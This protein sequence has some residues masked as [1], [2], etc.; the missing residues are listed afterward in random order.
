MHVY[1]SLL[2]G[3]IMTKHIDRLKAIKLREKGMSYGQI[4]TKLGI[5]KGT[6][7]VWLRDMPLSESRISELR[8]FNPMR[9]E[10]YRNTMRKKRETRWGFVYDQVAKD[11]G[12][13][14]KRDVFIAGLF[15]YWGEGGKTDRYSITFTNTDPDMV[16][17]FIKWAEE[18]FDIKRGTFSVRLHLYKDM[19]IDQYRKFWS[20]YLQIP[21]RNF[22]KPHVK[23]SSLTGLTYKNGFG[24]GTCN[25]R[26][27]N[28]DITEYVTQ[29]LKYLRINVGVEGLEPPTD[30]V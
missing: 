30:R 11:I 4:K 10:R 20:K 22:N 9:I 13:L 24:K 21:Q 28:R 16:S 23:D 6:L 15:L 1:Q 19:D 2:T 27:S 14:S 3:F 7:S 8:D 26:V 5:G 18:C 25:V 17:F 29:A 12:V